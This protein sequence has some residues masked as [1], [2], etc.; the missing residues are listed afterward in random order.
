MAEL[1]AGE[2]HVWCAFTRAREHRAIESLEALLSPDERERVGRCLC[3]EQRQHYVLARAL[4]RATLSRYADVPPTDWAFAPSRDGRPEV[5][6]PL[7]ATRLRFSA[8]HTSELVACAVALERDL[9]VD[10]EHLAARCSLN[11]GRRSRI[12]ERFFSPPEAR[13]LGRLPVAARRRAVTLAGGSRPS[14]VSCASDRSPDPSRGCSLRIRLGNVTDFEL[15]SIWV[16]EEHRI[17]AA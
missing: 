17:V 2:V 7:H 9:G 13:A 16:C 12:A 14:A 5:V 15:D 8:T 10:A 11:D 6:A 1:A 3:A 4:V